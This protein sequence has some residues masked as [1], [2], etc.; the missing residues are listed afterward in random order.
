L[1]GFVNGN[2]VLN[3]RQVYVSCFEMVLRYQENNALN[4]FV[5]THTHTHTHTGTH[6]KK[7][8]WSQNNEALGDGMSA[9]NSHQNKH[10]KG[11]KMDQ[12]L[13]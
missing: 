9:V 5:H 11:D 4:M 6:Q 7:Y 2:L 8:L 10:K 12:F 3:T 1:R 13:T